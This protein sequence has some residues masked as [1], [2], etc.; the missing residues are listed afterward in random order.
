ML[1]MSEKDSLFS[2][3]RGIG[4]GTYSQAKSALAQGLGRKLKKQLPLIESNAKQIR[5]QQPCRLS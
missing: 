2:L 4:L 5:I 3:L 1:Y